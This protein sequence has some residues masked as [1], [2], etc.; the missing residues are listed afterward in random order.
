MS[1]L[2]ALLLSP[3]A[4]AG[5]VLKDC[6]TDE[7]GKSFDTVNT[8][9]TVAFIV[10]IALVVTSFITGKPFDLATYSLGVSALLAATCG[11]QRYKP[12]AIPD[13]P[14]APSDTSKGPTS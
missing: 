4:T 11:A 6:T 8:A 13:S 9:A 3:F 5:R 7:Y 10:G 1:K 12:P 2:L 14:A